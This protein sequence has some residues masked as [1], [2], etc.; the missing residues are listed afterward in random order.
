MN[1]L[2]EID[3]QLFSE[4]PEGVAP[5]PEASSAPE[6]EASPESVGE[7]TPGDLHQ[8]LAKVEGAEGGAATSSPADSTPPLPQASPTPPV[9]TQQVVQIPADLMQTLGQLAM[10]ALPAPETPKGPVIP[11]PVLPELPEPPDLLKGTDEERQQ[12]YYEDPIAFQEAMFDHRMKVSQ[13]Q[14]ERNR[15]S[16]EH[17]QKV[18]FAERTQ[19]F[20]SAFTK[21]VTTLGAQVFEQRAPQVESLLKSN[22]ALMSLP[23]E[24]AVQTAFNLVANAVSSQFNPASLTPEQK[25]AVKAAFQQEVI[26]EYLKSVASGQRPPVTITGAIP[27]GKPPMTP[28]NA[29]QTLEEAKR[30]WLASIPK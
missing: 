30:Q 19:A 17:K 15:I 14:N 2:F 22:P 1:G 6:V 12:R 25:Q 10:R 27:S 18:A 23:P 5:T 9:P 21:Q 4:V 13:V 16:A 29:P 20:Q 8:F 11:D 26:Q 28:P 7:A 24:Q 3:L